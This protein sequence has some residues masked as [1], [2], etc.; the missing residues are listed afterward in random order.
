[1][2]SVDAGQDNSP[3]GEGM[4]RGDGSGGGADGAHAWIIRRAVQQ[5]VW[6]SAADRGDGSMRGAAPTGLRLGG[7]RPGWMA[8]LDDG[9]IV[10]GDG[11]R[12]GGGRGG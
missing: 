11:S 6:T 2:A 8:G 7:G 9:V 12:G 1:M 4:G 3:R 10:E 5:S